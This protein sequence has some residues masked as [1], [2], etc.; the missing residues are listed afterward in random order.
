MSYIHINTML[1]KACEEG[2]LSTDSKDNSHWPL[3]YLMFDDALDYIKCLAS[4]KNVKTQ[5]V[6]KVMPLVCGNQ[7]REC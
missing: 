1:I 6:V 2:S 5:I 3:H 4:Q 7:K